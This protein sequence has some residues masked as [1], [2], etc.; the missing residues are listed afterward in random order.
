MTLRQ[1][2]LHFPHTRKAATVPVTPRSVGALITTLLSYF[3]TRSLSEL[4][5]YLTK[6]EHRTLTSQPCLPIVIS[7]VPSKE[8][9]QLVEDF[10]GFEEEWLKVNLLSCLIMTWF[11]YYYCCCNNAI[12]SLNLQ[13]TAFFCY[14]FQKLEQVYAVILQKEEGVGLG[15]SIAGGSDLENKAPTVSCTSTLHNPNVYIF[16]VLL[17]VQNFSKECHLIKD[18]FNH[19]GKGISN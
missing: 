19:T 15:F 4:R 3:V 10:R 16:S 6:P 8:V 14:Y 12:N 11:Y 18:Y 2:R 5:D 13:L 9:E 17:L 1:V 7:T